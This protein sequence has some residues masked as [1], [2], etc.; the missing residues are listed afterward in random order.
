MVPLTKGR[1][2]DEEDG[3]DSGAAQGDNS[4]KPKKK[5]SAKTKH[6][7]GKSKK[8]MKEKKKK[9]GKNQADF[10]PCS[11]QAAIAAMEKSEEKARKKTEVNLLSEEEQEAE[12]GGRF[13]SKRIKLYVANCCEKK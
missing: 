2:K 5:A 3:S 4:E 9:P 12:E 6:T 11:L 10:Q 8:T 7:K 13:M 1:K